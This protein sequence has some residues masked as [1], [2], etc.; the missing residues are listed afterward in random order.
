MSMIGNFFLASDGDLLAV[1]TNPPT[2]HNFIEAAYNTDGDLFLDVDKAWHCLHFLL[3]GL[4]E[5]GEPPL[6]FIAGGGTEVGDEDLGYGPARSFLSSD[7]AIIDEALQRVGRQDLIRRFDANRMDI[8]QI[9]PDAGRW[10]E[11]DSGSDDTFGYY[12]HA[13]DSLKALIVRGRQRGLG[14]LV[15]LS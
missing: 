10:S 11:V 13:F 1:Q 4:P 12:S 8:L 5:G 9:Y 15:W 2:V 7:L 14:M 3:T 6:N